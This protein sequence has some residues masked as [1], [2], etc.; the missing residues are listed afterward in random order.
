MGYLRRIR[1][2]VSYGYLRTWYV[3]NL[4]LLALSIWD[5]SRETVLN[6]QSCLARKLPSV[7]ISDLRK[8]RMTKRYSTLLGLIVLFE[9]V[10]KLLGLAWFIGLFDAKMAFVAY[11]ADGPNYW[12][13]K[14]YSTPAAIVSP[15]VTL[16]AA[17][18]QRDGRSSRFTLTNRPLKSG[19]YRD[20]IAW[21]S[22]RKCPN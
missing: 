7:S 10:T 11:Y 15:E 20:S 9:A 1:M 6:G 3:V 14:W 4:I 2:Y 22:R 12:V 8:G 21:L 16:P 18:S 19:I 17:P 5:L 13:R